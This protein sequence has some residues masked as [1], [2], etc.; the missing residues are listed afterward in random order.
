MGQK[1]KFF[2]KKSAVKFKVVHRSQYDPLIA[3]ENAPKYVLVPVAGDV[4]RADEF[5]NYDVGEGYESGEEAGKDSKYSRLEKQAQYGVYYDDDYDY[6]QHLREVGATD[7]VVIEA[8]PPKRSVCLDAGRL[9][10]GTHI[11]MARC[12]SANTGA[13]MRGACQGLATHP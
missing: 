13:L 2:D 1:K 8:A 12:V 3:D 4:A 5:V 6:M 9:D 10:V 7:A 11:H